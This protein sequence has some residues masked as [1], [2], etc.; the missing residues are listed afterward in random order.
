MRKNIVFIG[1]LL[2]SII[3]L[4]GCAAKK[5]E[6]ATPVEQYYYECDLELERVMPGYINYD[7]LLTSNWAMEYASYENSSAT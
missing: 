5:E 3:C 2:F 7:F 4:A 6:T 1:I